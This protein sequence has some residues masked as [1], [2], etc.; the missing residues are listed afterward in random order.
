M[1]QIFLMKQSLHS[2]EKFCHRTLMI[3][4]NVSVVAQLPILFK[5]IW[6]WAPGADPGFDQGGGPRS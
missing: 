4:I 2:F 3:A 1:S 5:V 6:A